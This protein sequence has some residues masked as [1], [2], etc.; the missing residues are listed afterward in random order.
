MANDIE[1]PLIPVSPSKESPPVPKQPFWFRFLRLAGEGIRS[2][3]HLFTFFLYVLSL[4][5]I[6]CILWKTNKMEPEYQIPYYDADGVG[7]LLYH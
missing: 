1:M 4:V 2:K 6:G 7:F 5:T 3:P